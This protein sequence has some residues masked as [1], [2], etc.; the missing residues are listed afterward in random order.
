MQKWE[1]LVASFS[2]DKGWL[3]KEVNYQKPPGELKK[4][5]LPYILQLYG[6][7]G[8]ELTGTTSFAPRWLELYFKRPMGQG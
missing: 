4:C 3:L 2:F 5:L 6:A 8:W 7:D 1:Y